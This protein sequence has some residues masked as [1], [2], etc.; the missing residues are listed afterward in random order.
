MTDKPKKQFIEVCFRDGGNGSPGVQ[1]YQ[2][3]HAVLINRGM[4]AMVPI[5][6]QEGVLYI[7]PDAVVYV[8]VLDPADLPVS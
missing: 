3:T 2:A 5:N 4:T 1:R 6:V 8:R 7:N